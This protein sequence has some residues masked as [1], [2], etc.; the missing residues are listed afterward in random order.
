MKKIIIYILI[1]AVL[2]LFLSIFWPYIKDAANASRPGDALGGEMFLWLCPPMIVYA[3]S[4]IVSR[5]G[6]KKS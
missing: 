6:R 5:K 3:F 4:K 1:W 2:C